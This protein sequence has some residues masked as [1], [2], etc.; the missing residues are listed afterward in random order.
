MSYLRTTEHR[1]LR[2]ELIRKWK[3]WE[4]STGPKTEEG[5]AASAGNSWKHGGRALEFR[6]ELRWL[7]DFLQ[8]CRRASY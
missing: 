3:P 6:E 4:Q 5:K 8:D 2:A 7:R 1:K